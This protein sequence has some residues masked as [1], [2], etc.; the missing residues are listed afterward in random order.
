MKNST[1]SPA[2]PFNVKMPETWSNIS[3]NLLFRCC[4]LLILS[5]IVLKFLFLLE[6]YTSPII[7]FT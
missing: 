5:S 2:I 1:F 6:T 3:F 7:L 4:N